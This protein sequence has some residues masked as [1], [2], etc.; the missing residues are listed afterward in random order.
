MTI[1][2][3]L[4]FLEGSL[5]SLSSLLG[6]CFEV[7]ITCLVAP[8]YSLLVA[9]HILVE[10]FP[11]LLLLLYLGLTS[12]EI[13][14]LPYKEE[15]HIHEYDE[16]STSYLNDQTDDK[17]RI[18][19]VVIW[20]RTVVLSPVYIGLDHTYQDRQDLQNKKNLGH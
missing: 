11:I 10:S 13:V 20:I 1:N 12:F 9:N 15:Q 19:T 16:C 7:S 18:A 14:A 3:L 2:V 17:E 6:E 8:V 5:Y 4:V